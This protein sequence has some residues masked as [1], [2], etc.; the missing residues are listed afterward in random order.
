[1]NALTRSRPSSMNSHRDTNAASGITNHA[2]FRALFPVAHIAHAVCRICSHDGMHSHYCVREMMYGS[3][4]VFDYFQCSTCG[5]LQIAQI[6]HDLAR[7]YRSDYYSL[8]AD[9][10]TPY[11]NPVKNALNRL[12]D[13][14]TLFAPQGNRLPGKVSVPHLAASFM[15]L[16]RVHGLSLHMR[17]LDVGCGSGQLLHRLENAGFQRLTGIDP[18]VAE[19]KRFS[20]RLT[21]L[22]G[23]LQTLDGQFDLILLNHAFEHVSNPI[24]AARRLASILAPGGTLLLRIPVVDGAA[25]KLYGCDWFQLDAP[26]HLYLHSDRSLRHV[27]ADAG[28]KVVEVHHDSDYHQFQMSERFLADVPTIVPE[29]ERDKLRTIAPTP[30]QIRAWKQMAHSLNLLGLGDQACFYLTHA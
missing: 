4:E 27:A 17:L 11:R 29:E 7:H 26:R 1:M 24:D 28:L 16:R 8:A 10:T 5:C 14:I 9:H 2:R 19:S 21:I 30:V 3:R 13:Q 6:P 20:D 25:W 15:A 22:K 12:R 23:E 18:F